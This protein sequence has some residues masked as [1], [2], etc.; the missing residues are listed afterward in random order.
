M[1]VAAELRERAQRCRDIAKDYHPCVGRP[2]W[3]KARALDVEAARLERRGIERRGTAFGRRALG[4][5]TQA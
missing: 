3:T 1:T 4:Q 5:A 2:L